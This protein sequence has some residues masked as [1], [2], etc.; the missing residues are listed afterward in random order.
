MT[1]SP[2]SI[3]SS[4]NKITN[5]QIAMIG[6]ARALMGLP[7]EHPFETLKTWMQSEN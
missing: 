3:L 1:D 7:I 6:G 2:Q 5:L 4:S